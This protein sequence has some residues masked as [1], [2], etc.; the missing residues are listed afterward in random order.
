MD[1]HSLNMFAEIAYDCLDEEQSRRQNIDDIVLR[2]E[3]ALVLARENRQVRLLY[4]LL[5]TSGIIFSFA[6]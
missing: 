5:N 6:F 3:K 4:F 2:L 1:L